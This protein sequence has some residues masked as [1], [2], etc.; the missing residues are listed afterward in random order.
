MYDEGS[1]LCTRV[2]NEPEDGGVS[3]IV[4]REFQANDGTP[5]QADSGTPRT[6]RYQ[7]Y[8]PAQKGWEVGCFFT[9]QNGA[10]CVVS[11]STVNPGTQVAQ[12]GQIPPDASANVFQIYEETDFSVLNLTPA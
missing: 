9:V 8:I 2:E 12:A 4:T 10:A 5:E 6:P 1:L 11:S 7:P 3:Y